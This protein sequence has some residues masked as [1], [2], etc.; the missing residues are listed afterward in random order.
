MG[1]LN[2]IKRHAVREGKLVA[3][4]MNMYPP[5]RMPD[6]TLV[7]PIVWLEHIGHTNQGFMLEQLADAGK[8]E[9]AIAAIRARVNNARRTLADIEKTFDDDRELL[10]RHSV[11]RIDGWFYDG[12]D[13]GPDPLSPVPSTP[14]GIR[15]VVDAWDTSAINLALRIAINAENYREAAVP[16]PAADV[17]KK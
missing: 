14:E 7:E 6:G 13:G 11:R 4:K 5:T 17:A 8:K 12:D 9:D 1:T 3:V 15:N 2:N 16:M 10:L